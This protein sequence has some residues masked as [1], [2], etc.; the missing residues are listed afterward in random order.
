MDGDLTDVA[1]LAAVAERREAMLIIDEAHATGVWGANGRGMAAA[2]HG[3]PNVLTLN[4]FGKA[5]GCEGAVLC[6]PAIVRDFLVA[7][8]R[9]FIFSTA[10]APLAPP[11]PVPAS[12]IGADSVPFAASDTPA[13]DPAT[14][15]TP[16][17]WNARDRS[18]TPRP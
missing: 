16:T 1:A 11:L 12:P 10:P 7:R 18:S 13:P 14:V 2:L 3:R 5:L 6:G 4:T 17:G 15:T 8:A 9:P